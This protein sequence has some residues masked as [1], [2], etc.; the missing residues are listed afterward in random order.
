MD[1][2]LGYFDD[3]ECRGEP[4]DNP[5]GAKLSLMSPK[6]Y[7]TYSR[8]GHLFSPGISRLIAKKL[9]PTV[10][11]LLVLAIS[12]RRVSFKIRGIRDRTASRTPSGALLFYPSSTCCYHGHEGRMFKPR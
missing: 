1:Y 10:P 9:G 7:V 12:T 6:Q 5:F 8:E 3:T 11:M 2:N 4:A